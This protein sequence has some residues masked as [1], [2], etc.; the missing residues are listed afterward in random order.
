MAAKGKT[1]VKKGKAKT[2]AKTSSSR[3]KKTKKK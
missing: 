1:T 3:V 2:K